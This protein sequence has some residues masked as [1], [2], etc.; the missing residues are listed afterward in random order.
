MSRKTEFEGKDLEE[1]IRSASGTL[2]IPEDEL[3]YEII[4]AG[5]RGVLGFGVKDVKIRV[6]PPVDQLTDRQ[7]RD[8]I[9]PDQFP[10]PGSPI[11]C[12]SSVSSAC[13]VASPPPK[14]PS[15]RPA[16]STR[17]QGT[18][19]GTGLAPI[20]CPTARA[21]RGWPARWARSP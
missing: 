11:S 9:E 5:R 1:A 8:G 2:N 6:M 10:D 17:C 16:A 20:T 13:F 15:R 12:P 19:I 21:A 4:E 3:H 14:P 18:T 7:I